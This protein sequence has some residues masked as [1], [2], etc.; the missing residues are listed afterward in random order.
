[1]HRSS[2]AALAALLAAAPFATAAGDHEGGHAGGEGE[3]TTLTGE[4]IDTAC[5]VASD[6]GAKGE[7]HAECASTCL[8]TGIPAGILPEGGDTGDL[9]FLLTNP[10]PLAEYAAQTIKVEGVAHEGMQSFDVKHLYVQQEDGGFKEVTLD[11]N[12]HNMTGGDTKEED[13]G[14]GAHSH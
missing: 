11:D 4:L 8:A 1:M 14:H 3:M 5:F 6:G 7:G 13:H 2:C 12:H 9:L 10:V